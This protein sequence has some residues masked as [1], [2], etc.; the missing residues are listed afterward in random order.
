[1]PDPESK[2]TKK[3]IKKNYEIKFLINQVLKNNIKKNRLE[4]NIKNRPWKPH[5]ETQTLY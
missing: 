3:K 2:I 5:K 1:M 4:K